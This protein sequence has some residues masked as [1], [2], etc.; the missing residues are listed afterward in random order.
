MLGLEG[1]YITMVGIC[2]FPSF[3]ALA[4]LC[5]IIITIIEITIYASVYWSALTCASCPFETG[6]ARLLG[7]IG[8]TDSWDSGYGQAERC[9]EWNETNMSKSSNREWMEEQKISVTNH[10]RKNRVNRKKSVHWPS[11]MKNNILVWDNSQI[12]AALEFQAK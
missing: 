8:W 9:E 2:F 5:K 12:L 10:L 1:R 4:S 7:A 11:F 6:R 3:V